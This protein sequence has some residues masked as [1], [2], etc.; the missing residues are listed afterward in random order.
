[1]KA[2]QAPATTTVA[3]ARGEESVTLT[4]SA[5]PMGYAAHLERVYPQPTE[6]VNGVRVPLTAATYDWRYDQNLLNVA[7]ALGDQ[8]DA[9]PP[10]S[11]DAK[12][13]GEY[14]RAIREELTAAHLTEGHL[15]QIVK[16]LHELHQGDGGPG[17]AS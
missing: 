2:F 12:A 16:A 7:K 17:K 6:M 1:M 5:L 8:I 9:R 11:S 14:A 4:L 15:L 3:L 13:W 10:T